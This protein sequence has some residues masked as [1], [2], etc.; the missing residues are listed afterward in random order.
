MERIG[1]NLFVQRALKVARKPQQF[2]QLT[3]MDRYADDL[4]TRAS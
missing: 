2:G 3:M 1:L 4:A